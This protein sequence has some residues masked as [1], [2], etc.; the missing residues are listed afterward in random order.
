M[1]FQEAIETVCAYFHPTSMEL[2]VESLINGVLERSAPSRKTIGHLLGQLVLR[3]ILLRKQYETGLR[4][5][6]H[7]AGDLVVDI[8]KVWDYLGELIGNIF[9]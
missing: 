8:P 2:L 5:V 7:Y 9:Y 3:H 6:L 4:S 1:V